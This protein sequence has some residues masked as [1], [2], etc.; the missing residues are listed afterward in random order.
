MAIPL[1]L[2]PSAPLLAIA[3]L[4]DLALGDPDYRWHPVRLMGDS[5]QAIERGLRRIGFDAYGGGVLLFVLLAGLWVTGVS[6]IVAVAGALLTWAGFLLHLF[7]LYSF[8]ALGSLL[9]HGRRIEDA[10]RD[11]DLA[12]AR[13]A[14]SQL[15]G[16][17]T[18]RMD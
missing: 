7:A 18:T 12:R 16:R 11:A 1:A 2:L 4:L 15:V 6:A 10:L 14:V 5:L 17:D 3:T 13:T 9:R 8:L